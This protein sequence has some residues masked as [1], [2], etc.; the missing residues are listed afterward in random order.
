MSFPPFLLFSWAAQ[1]PA[2]GHS[3]RRR[4][5]GT[6]RDSQGTGPFTWG[7]LQ[8]LSK[9]EGIPP[10]TLPSETSFGSTGDL[11]FSQG[12]VLGGSSHTGLLLQHSD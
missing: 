2:G 5:A 1:G 4:L 11:V 8:G 6:R 3:E 7:F 12:I 9:G 10:D